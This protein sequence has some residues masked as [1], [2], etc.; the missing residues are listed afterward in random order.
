[1]FSENNAW[2]MET[3]SGNGKLLLI[4]S[5]VTV[6]FVQGKSTT[7]DD[8]WAVYSPFSISSSPKTVGSIDN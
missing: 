5:I 1:F 3:R 4:T 8:S 2:C 7:A 6:S